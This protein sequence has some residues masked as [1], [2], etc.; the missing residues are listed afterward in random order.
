MAATRSTAAT[1]SR[2]G[3]ASPAPIAKAKE[4]G[5][6]VSTAARKA[7][8]PLIAAGASAAGLAGGLV[9]GSRLARRRDSAVIT[10]GRALGRAAREL[11][12]ATDRVTE[13]GD[14]VRQVREQLD[15]V[16]RQSPVEVL[17]DGLTHRRG[18][19][20]REG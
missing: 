16:N 9:L 3:S 6:T 12:S 19:H 15:R 13:T 4:A 2:N 10:V 18:A 20:K 17:L 5:E 1:A 8:G 7:K 14:E 11:A